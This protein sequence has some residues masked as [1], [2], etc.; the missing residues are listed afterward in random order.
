MK[1][2]PPRLCLHNQGP[3]GSPEV[4]YLLFAALFGSCYSGTTYYH[5]QPSIIDSM[6]GGVP[7]TFVL[8]SPRP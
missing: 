3:M 4:R 5:L 6:I 7:W 8:R 2:I 1:K